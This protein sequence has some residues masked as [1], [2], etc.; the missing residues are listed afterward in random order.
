M[1]FNK[2]IDHHFILYILYLKGSPRCKSFFVRFPITSVKYFGC[3]PNPG[4]IDL[5]FSSVKTSPAFIS[6]TTN[7]ERENFRLAFIFSVSSY[8]ILPKAFSAYWTTVTIWI[9][10]F[11]SS[12]K[13]HSVRELIFQI[14]NSQSLTTLPRVNEM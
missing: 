13:M 1:S 11:S 6:L 3:K 14:S 10:S 8:V 2:F 9:N 5:T 12:K 7:S 4:R